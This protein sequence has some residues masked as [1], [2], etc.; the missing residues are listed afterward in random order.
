[1]AEEGEEKDRE[2][3]QKIEGLL[4]RHPLKFAI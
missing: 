1:M 4:C 3:N 2:K